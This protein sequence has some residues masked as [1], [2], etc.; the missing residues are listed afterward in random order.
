MSIAK[1]A[2]RYDLDL[3]REMKGAQ[4]RHG[5]GLGKQVSDFL[6]LRNAG[7][8]LSFEEY[9]YFS[10]FNRPR[11]EF[12]SY[13]GDHRA[14]AAFYLANDLENWD[15]AEDKF[16]FAKRMI[17]ADL[18]TPRIRASAHPDRDAGDFPML[19]T[20]DELARFL[21]ECALPIFGKPMKGSHG[22]GAVKLVTRKGDTLTSDD[23]VTATIEDLLDAITPYFEDAGYLFQ[24]AL[25]PHGDIARITDGRVATLRFF[26]IV[27]PD[28]VA[29]KHIVMR[30][31]A[32]ENRVDNFRRSGNLIAPVD[33]E[34]GSLG[35][36]RRGVGVV[37]EQCSNHPD[38]QLPIEGVALPD[39]E[40]AKKIVREAAALFTN[41]HIQSW[42]VALTPTGP[43]L[44]E[45][46]PG[47]NFNIL[48]LANGRGVFDEEF[49]NFLEWCL[50]SNRKA[51]DNPKALKEAK[52][53]LKLK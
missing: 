17:A 53:L 44:L 20:R 50:T 42:D 29:I 27:G 34:K 25:T 32:G 52:K 39:F 33:I 21:R 15:D 8:G 1:K 28:G 49:R 40:K 5:V 23:G 16:N 43:S 41:Q 46:N 37:S 14:R 45:V 30:F 36:A 4:E 48:Q 47:G 9:H 18:P 19:R 11:A 38:T 26:V 31:P 12:S 13:M 22:D 3:M 35:A 24:E 10:L 7:T 2:D 51:A 6:A